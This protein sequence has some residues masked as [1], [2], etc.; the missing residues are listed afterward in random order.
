MLDEPQRLA[1]EQDLAGLGRLLEPRGDVDR[2]PGR[3]PLLRP[4]HHFARVHASPQ[5]EARAVRLGKLGV[6]VA[7]RVAKLGSGPDRPERVVLV[8]CGNAE[9]GHHGVA[10][11]LFDSAAVALD[12]GLGDLEVPGHHAPQAFRVQERAV[13]E[14]DYAA[15][16]QRHPDVQRTV[17]TRRW[18]G[19]WNTMFITVDRKGGRSVDAEFEQELRDFLER[20]RLAG[21]DLEIDGPT[22][23]PLDLELRVCVLTGYLR[24]EVKKAL[25]EKF[26]VR[27]LP[28]GN[29][30]FFHPD[31]FTFGQPVYL[32][33]IVAAAMQ[34]Q[35]VHWVE[36]ARFRRWSQLPAGEIDAG[37]MSFARLEIARLDNDPNA[38]ENG[39]L[40]F[41]MEGGA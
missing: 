23:V 28:D 36:V 4:C 32:S 7:E 6:E 22:F 16:S 31:N 40:E 8:H 1:A 12:H 20:F 26:S 25:L 21:Q 27:E 18:T 11:E 5:L 10:D 38:P 39:K 13:T 30:G 19:S 3:Q 35:G 34:V 33:A 14:A 24:S 15:V 41:V 17:A 29:R 2:V 9:D 37:Q